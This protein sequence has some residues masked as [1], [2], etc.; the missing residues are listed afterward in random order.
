MALTSGLNVS[1]VIDDVGAYRRR[2]ADVLAAVEIMLRDLG[3]MRLYRTACPRVG[4]LSV[5]AGLTAWCD[6]RTLT[7]QHKG[8]NTAW[9]VTDAE[10][11]ARRLAKLAGDAA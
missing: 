8:E 9:P 2:P 6:G 3:L 5:T 4:V 1:Y 11:A 10:G 7:W